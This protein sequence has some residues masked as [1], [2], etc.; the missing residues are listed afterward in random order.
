MKLKGTTGKMSRTIKFNL[1]MKG[2]AAAHTSM[3]LL[4]PVM[5]PEVF[6]YVSVGLAVTIAM[7]NEYLRTLTTGPLHDGDQL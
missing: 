1:L 7:G 5:S 6:G 3:Q 4:Q 2:I